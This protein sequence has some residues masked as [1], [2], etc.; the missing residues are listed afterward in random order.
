MNITL[1]PKTHGEERGFT[2]EEVRRGIPWV[3]A[4]V[5]CPSFGKEQPLAVTGYI[6]GPCCACGE[7]T[8]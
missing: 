8:K 5:K 3:Y 4:D 7:L 2:E 1:Y 6:G